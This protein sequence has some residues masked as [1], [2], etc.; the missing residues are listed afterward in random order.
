MLLMSATTAQW[1]TAFED[2]TVSLMA[3]VIG[4][5]GAAITQASLT[6]IKLYAYNLADTTT[7]VADNVTVVIAS[8]VYDTLQTASPWDDEADSE[9]Y[10]FRYDVPQTYLAS[11]GRYR[12]EF[13]FDPAS[14][15]DFFVVFQ[16]EAL[17]LVSS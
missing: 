13:R 1:F 15:G 7:P 16:G 4:N 17:N 12:F 14:G 2:G 5:A 6:A 3:R 8:T 10:N 9:G 11:P